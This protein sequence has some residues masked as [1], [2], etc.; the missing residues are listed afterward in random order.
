MRV[1]ILVFFKTSLF[2][3]ISKRNPSLLNLALKEILFLLKERSFVT[4]AEMFNVFSASFI[5]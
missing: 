5:N 2:E 1:F 3:D 4:E